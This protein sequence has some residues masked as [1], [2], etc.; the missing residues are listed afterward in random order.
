MDLS[1]RLEEKAE[2]IKKE[3]A[4]DATK[5]TEMSRL[6][7]G[8]GLAMGDV[9]PNRKTSDFLKA[10]VGWVYACAGVIADEIA[11]IKIKLY[12]QSGDKVIEVT[13]H[14]ALDIIQRVNPFTTKF[15]HFWLSA[16]YLELTGEAPW[17]VSFKGGRP[18]QLMLLRPD[19]LE[20]IQGTQGNIING[21]KYQVGGSKIVL[22]P[23]EVVFLKFPNPDR[24]F[25]GMGPLQAVA[26]TID[27]EEYSE[28]Y[29]RKFFFN[30]A[31]PDGIL[32]TEQKLSS[33]QMTKVEKKLNQKFRGYEN[34]H[35]TLILEKGL[36]WQ[37]M[38][39]SQ[40]DM[41]FL[42]QA[43]FSRDKILGIFRVPRT[44]LG[45]TDDVNRANAEATDYVFSKRTIKPKMERMIQQLNEFLL[46]LFAGT[47]N[48]FYDFDDPVPENQAGEL[49]E[50][51][52][53]MQYGWLTRNEVRAMSGLDP[54]E[55]GDVLLVPAGLT[56]IGTEPALPAPANNTNP[57]HFSERLK[58]M[59]ARTR[60]KDYSKK[61]RSAIEQEL[62]K[63]LKRAGGKGRK[64]KHVKEAVADDPKSVAFQMKQLNIADEF[65]HRY[66]IGVSRVFT[67]QKEWI[68]NKMGDKAFKADIDWKKFLLLPD[69]EKKRFADELSKLVA[70]IIIA[71]AT[72]AF[73]FIG[74]DMRF[75]E[76][77]PAL[78][79]YFK[80]KAFKFSKVTTVY[81]NELLASAFKEGIDAGESIPELRKRV[82]KVFKRM[83]KYR[84]ERIARTETI[85]ATNYASEAAYQDSGIV[86]GK[87][88]LT[89][90]DERT[91]EF[92]GP[93]N[94]QVVDLGDKWFDRGDTYVGNQG[95][96]LDLSYESIEFPPL[97]PNCRCT[98]IPVVM[99]EAPKSVDKLDQD[100]DEV[101]NNIKTDGE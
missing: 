58:Q 75:D 84:S 96:S 32:S 46:P 15:D 91:C 53:A 8:P 26:R 51:K 73:E 12:R 22:E 11:S 42:N 24:Q 94:G 100:L 34:A 57:K 37:A 101:L 47:D 30:S 78:A 72:E 95:G 29:N 43:N 3:I 9:P 36:K 31:R 17:F 64:H 39:I 79:E 44:V 93:M 60:E 20:V 74:S 25:R 48:M 62:V 56:P 85:K 41:D 98:L 81:T 45:I 99:R 65:E 82:E 19:A 68:L 13:N 35:K 69:K 66:K 38:G 59:G 70:E 97:H 87:Q 6:M 71:Q 16:Q 49:E 92:C 61:L 7:G 50:K 23:Q 10:S 14:P 86:Q 18:D 80:D 83:E 89:A 76:N 77:S 27:I 88:W 52:A 54:V 2:S 21:Y 1:N 63:I 5:A 67:A 33:D 28:E 4:S 40:K 55:D 90:F